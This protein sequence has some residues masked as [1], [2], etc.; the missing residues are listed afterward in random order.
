MTRPI[1]RILQLLTV[2][3]HP[4]GRNIMT[5]FFSF[6]PC[7][8]VLWMEIST[9]REN[10]QFCHSEEINQ[11]NLTSPTSRNRSVSRSS[12]NSEEKGLTKRRDSTGASGKGSSDPVGVR[13]R[14]NSFGKR[15]Q[16]SQSGSSIGQGKDLH[17]RTSRTTHTS[18][19]NPNF[20]IEWAA[21]ILQWSRK[22]S[23]CSTIW[24]SKITCCY[25]SW[26]SKETWWRWCLYLGPSGMWNGYNRWRWRNWST[27]W[28][29]HRLWF[30]YL[31]TH[32]WR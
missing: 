8:Y 16:A 31:W 12:S 18:E 22:G 28:P 4:I 21:R 1:F 2:F 10:E 9:L 27:Q 30:C 7:L 6:L 20:S 24:G 11:P 3:R 32:W 29:W 17:I 23:H 5:N 14:R 15:S 19:S 13:D 25:W 26:S